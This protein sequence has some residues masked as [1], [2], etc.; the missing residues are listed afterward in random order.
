LIPFSIMAETASRSF[1]FHVLIKCGWKLE[2]RNW[3]I[4]YGGNGNGIQAERLL[5]RKQYMW[6]PPI[7]KFPILHA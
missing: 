5:L 7:S 6:F 3:N 2:S 1:E 4:L